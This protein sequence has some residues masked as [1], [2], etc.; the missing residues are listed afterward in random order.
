MQILGAGEM[1]E[2]IKALDA[3]PED[4]SSIPDGGRRGLTSASSASCPL[5][6]THMPWYIVSLHPYPPSLQ[7]NRK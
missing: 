2:Q 5:I 1:P 3:K 4:M 6:F 7:M